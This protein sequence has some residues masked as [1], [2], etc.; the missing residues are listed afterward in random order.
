LTPLP[1]T[2]SRGSDI[3]NPS[4]GKGLHILANFKVPDSS[5]LENQQSFKNFIAL[6]LEEFQLPKTE[7]IFN[8]EGQGG[9]SCVIRMHDSRFSIQTRPFENE[10][11]FD[12]FLSSSIADNLVTFRAFYCSM[13]AYFNAS[14]F[15]EEL[16]LR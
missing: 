9:F 4:S 6:L 16:L 11:T 12:L 10:L 7:E 2:S 13:K 15:S 14:V 5:Q 1:V 8:D 3:S